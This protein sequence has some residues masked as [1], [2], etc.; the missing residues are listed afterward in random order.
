M[1]SEDETFKKLSR[2]S[3]EEMLRLFNEWREPVSGP[4]DI[5]EFL[6]RHKWTYE[7]YIQEMI[8]KDGLY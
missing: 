6:I 7:E 8:K 3:F 2:V 1:N 5:S 4:K